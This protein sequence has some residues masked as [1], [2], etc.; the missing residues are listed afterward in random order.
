MRKEARFSR[1]L[2]CAALIGAAGCKSASSAES[3]AFDR[4]CGA[5]HTVAN[6]SGTRAQGLTD[7][8]KRAALGQFLAKHHAPDATVR[9]Q[10]ID[11]LAGQEK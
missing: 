6:L 10:V 11:H 3:E 1:W 5:C 7:P 4:N 9:G 2:L 8:Q